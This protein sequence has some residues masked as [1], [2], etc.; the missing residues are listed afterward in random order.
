MPQFL[1]RIERQ[2]VDTP[3][4][5]VYR[6]RD[7]EL[8]SRLSFF[9]W[10]SIPDEELLD[11]AERNALS[12]PPTLRRQVHRMLADRRATRFMDDFVGQWL[13]MRNIFSQDPDGNLFAG[14]NDSLR[15]AM[16]RETELFFPESSAGGPVDPGPAASGLHLPQR[17][18]RA[19][20]RR[21]RSL[22]QPF[23]GGSPGTTTGVTGCWGT[24]AC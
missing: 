5:A 12:D 3:A 2:P 6:L 17:A 22:W 10:K 23:P 11:L 16:V 18:A 20:L 19:S 4:G 21:R 14:F 7:L 9:L 24:P 8:A 1:M 15:K 13:Q